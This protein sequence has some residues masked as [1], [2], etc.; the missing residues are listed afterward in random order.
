MKGKAINR[1]RTICAK[2]TFTLLVCF[3]ILML[4]FILLFCNIKYEVSDDFIMEMILSGVY[5][6]KN[7]VHIMFSNVIWAS[8]LLPLY[9]LFPGISWYLIGQ[10]SV[11]LLSYTA[12]SYV[13]SRNTKW[14]ISLSIVPVLTVFTAMDFYILPQFT[15]TA[16]AAIFA[17]CLLFIWALFHGGSPFQIIAGALLALVGS[18]IR[19]AS[20][21]IAAPFVAVLLVCETLRIWHSR[22]PQLAKHLRD[23]C[24]CCIL[25]LAAM[26]ASKA[27]DS[28]VYACDENYALY[29]AYSA[30]RSAIVDY[31][32]PYYP[33]IASQL[34]QIGFSE[35]DYEL[36]RNWC[37]GD[38][39]VF[40]LEKMQQ[41]QQL[42]ES[43]RSEHSASVR[44]FI[45]FFRHRQLCYPGAVLCIFAGLCCISVNWKNVPILFLTTS[46]VLI[47]F[48][49]FYQVNRNVYRVEFGYYFCA[50][51]LLACFCS[52]QATFPR[53]GKYLIP[54]LAV[55]LMLFQAD[56]YFPDLE[57]NL[58]AGEQYRAYVDET[59]YESWN[60]SQEKYT[61]IVKAG[62]IRP[63]FLELAAESSDAVY[64]L[65]FN[66]TI[67]T[68][69]YDF[70]LFRSASSVFPPN[71]V[72]LGGVTAY[73]PSAAPAD[74]GVG[75]GDLL[76]LLTSEN[77]YFVSTG[78]AERILTYLHEHLEPS[79]RME[80]C[81]AIDGYSV[82]KYTR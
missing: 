44:S 71:L 80:L 59:F 36:I 4:V 66:T 13:I 48:F 7:D 69:Y 22:D 23:I 81:E 10:L 61:R 52:P 16:T 21:Y 82:W 46:I 64:L 17:G 30:A 5:T 19:F 37:F 75:T 35:N 45:T 34:Q 65:D 1:I 26:L 51:V 73:H 15:K 32:L 63:G 18:W 39:E 8:L 57:S 56:H 68:L 3:H 2:R 27:L 70:S 20:I 54:I 28:Y 33:S 55:L 14:H 12:I 11:C 74:C 6:G 50:A 53:V 62:N 42:L 77:V 78:T 41:L 31:T 29:K 76:D 24:L 58:P 49:Y 60:Y 38:S 9:R 72:Y 79:I 67:Q 47:F 43:V 25:L 40:S